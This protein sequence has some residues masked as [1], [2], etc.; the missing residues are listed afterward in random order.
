MIKVEIKKRDLQNLKKD[1]NDLKPRNLLR[2]E[3]DPLGRDIIQEVRPYPPSVGYPRTGRLGRSWWY[4]TY[5]E[6]L[7]VGNYASYAGYVQGA[8]QTGYHKSH[9]WKNVFDVATTQAEKLIKKIINK[10]EQI[11][12][13]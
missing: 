13:S 4:R 10:A 12:R 9:G 11:W 2:G 5:G 8:E 6:D 7:E 1:L 3:L